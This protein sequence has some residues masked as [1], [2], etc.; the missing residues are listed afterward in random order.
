[1]NIPFNR[2][3][4]SGFSDRNHIEIC[5]AFRFPARINQGVESEKLERTA[6]LRRTP[7]ESARSGMAMERLPRS[8]AGIFHSNERRSLSVLSV[9]AVG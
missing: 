7:T 2:H 4:I 8:I 1:M 5:A 6:P 3:E 9:C